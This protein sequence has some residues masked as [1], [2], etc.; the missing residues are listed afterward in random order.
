MFL[1]LA[2]EKFLAFI[3]YTE[4]CIVIIPISIALLLFDGLEFKLCFQYKIISLY[5][6]RLETISLVLKIKRN[7]CGRRSFVVV[8]LF[9]FAYV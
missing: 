4:T 7:L 2:V 3:S 9:L 6:F 5:S 8:F 1:S